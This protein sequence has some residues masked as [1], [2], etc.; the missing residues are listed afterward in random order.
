MTSRAE[1]R[2]ILVMTTMPG[3]LLPPPP[4]DDDDAAE[5]AEIDSD[6]VAPDGTVDEV[7][8]GSGAKY[9]SW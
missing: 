5:R 6:D 3:V 9:A 8:C 4:D 1:T 7:T 2:R